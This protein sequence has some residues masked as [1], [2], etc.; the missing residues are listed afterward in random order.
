MAIIVG[1][2]VALGGAG[3]TTLSLSDG[4][5]RAVLWIALGTVGL[6]GIGF[7]ISSLVRAARFRSPD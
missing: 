2:L 3:L 6:V 5:G 4:D 7:G 1:A